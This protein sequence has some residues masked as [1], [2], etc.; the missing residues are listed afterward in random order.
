ME[1]KM[2][3]AASG[4]ALANMTPQRAKELISTM[5]VNSQQYRLLMGPTRRVHELSTPSVVNKIDELNNVVKNML[6][7]QTNPAR[8]YGICAKLDHPT[9]LYPILLEDTTVQVDAVGN[10][11]GSP[12]R[13][14]DPYSNTYNTG[15]REHPNLSY[16]SN[17]KCNQPYQPRPPTP[18]QYQP[19]KSSLEAIVERLAVSIEKFQKKTEVH[20]QELDQ[21]ISKLALTVSRLENQ[22]KLSSQTEPNPHQN[23]SVMIVKDGKE[24]ELVPGTSRNHDV[25]QEAEPAAPTNTAPHKPFVVPPLCPGRLAQIKKE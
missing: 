19:S 8:L 1:M 9:N 4:G 2:I 6:V 15:L 14:Y 20:F 18:Q 16:G 3:D 25:E 11:L 5:T 12:Q 24:S 7:G 10:F 22:E 23:A 21:Q 13:C 17:P